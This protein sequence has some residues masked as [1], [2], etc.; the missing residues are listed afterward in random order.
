MYDPLFAKE[1]VG[2]TEKIGVKTNVVLR[3]MVDMF[4]CAE[5]VDV[6]SDDDENRDVTIAE[7]ELGDKV[8]LA[9]EYRE[10]DEVGDGISSLADDVLVFSREVLENIEDKIGKL[11]LLQLPEMSILELVYDGLVDRIIDV[12]LM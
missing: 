10:Y 2:V 8:D 6:T 3:D 1:N 9:V 4:N 12:L 11:T 5:N 7:S